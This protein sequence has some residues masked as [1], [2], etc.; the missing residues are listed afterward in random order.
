MAGELT[1]VDTGGISQS[2]ADL[3]KLMADEVAFEKKI[4]EEIETNRNA[5][6]EKGAKERYLIFKEYALKEA[7]EAIQREENAVNA[8][9]KAELDKS[10]ELEKLRKRLKKAKTKDEQEEIQKAIQAEVKAVAKKY[11]DLEKLDEK[12]KKRLDQAKKKQER[13]AKAEQARKDREYTQKQSMALNEALFGKGV[14]LQDRGRAISKAFH[15][16]EDGSLNMA[17]GLATMA[18]AVSDFAKQLNGQIN[19]IA[20]YKTAID[21]RLQGSKMSTVK[22]L[23]GE[24]SY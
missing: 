2:F 15:Q 9:V 7:N 23:F 16:N 10:K 24:N 1:K 8:A 11:K 18:N 4:A 17:A 13:E 20:G 12:S 21:T 3:K 5:I 19:A 22:G 6:R 14:S